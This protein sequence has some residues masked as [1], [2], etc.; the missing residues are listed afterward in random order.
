MQ[1]TLTLNILTDE[2]LSVNF[3][4]KQYVLHINTQGKSNLLNRFKIFKYSY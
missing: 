1:I 3:L 4:H 2:N